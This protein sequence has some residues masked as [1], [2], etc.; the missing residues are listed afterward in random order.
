MS[1]TG[2]GTKTIMGIHEESSYGS[3]VDASDTGDRIPLLSEGI[4]FD[5]VDVVHEHLAASAGVSAQQRVF[6]PVTGTLECQVPYT[7]KSSTEFISAS[8]LLA[9]GM[10]TVTFPA[11]SNQ[12]TFLDDL[13]VYGTIAWDKGH[14]ATDV[15]QAISCFISA[16]SI[17]C[18]AG[19][20]M[21]ASFDIQAYD[22][23]ISNTTNSVTTLATLPSAV[24]DVDLVL[25]SDFVFRIGDQA[26]ALAAGD[27]IALSSFT[28]SVNNNL[29]EPQQTTL[30]ASGTLNIFQP[31]QP[32]RNG[33]RETT[34]EITLPRYDADT[35]LDF[36]TNDTNLQAEF[37]GTQPT[38]SEEFDILFPN[39]KVINVSAPV[40]GAEAIEQSVTFRCLKRNSA[41]DIV[42]SDGGGTN[43][44]EMW[45]ETDDDRTAVIY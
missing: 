30:P 37:F 8:L 21:T 42:F 19:E 38:S 12:L 4:E 25:F 11:D 3:R 18:N 17:S 40:A 23:D 14:H 43:A 1:P 15:W 2:L 5:N 33:F 6:E 10:G 26:G 22:I 35:F 45:I 29:T 24:V 13:N 41:S 34:L 39:L 27:Q 36:R 20:A 31:I 44:G 7:V 16:F 28:I 9:L 32:V